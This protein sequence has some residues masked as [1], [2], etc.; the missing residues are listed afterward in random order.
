MK[1]I[2]AL[3]LMGAMVFSLTACGGQKENAQTQ[4]TETTS[5]LENQEQNE[6]PDSGDDIEG[7]VLE[8]AVTYAG[9]QVTDFQQIVDAFEQEY[10]CKV[11]IA[12]YGSDYE[13][14][15]KTRMAA[16]N[17][18]DVFMTHGW[19]IIR[20]KDYLMDLR[21]E[22]WV[23]DYDESALGVIQDKDGAIYVLMIAE[24]INGT[25]VNKQVCEAAGVDPYSIHTWDDFT[26]ACATIKA[27]GYTPISVI[28]NP[29]LLANMAGT[30]VSYE[31]GLAQDSEVML[32]GSWDWESYRTVLDVYEEW[33]DAGYFY[34]DAMTMND[35]DLVERYANNAGAFCL[36]N[37]PEIM[38]ACQ[39]LNP[40]SEFLF[41]PSFASKEGGKEFVGIGEGGAFGIW[42]DTQNEKAAKL[43]LEYMAR[44]EVAVK[45][46]ASTG[47]ISCLKSAMEIDDGDG[48]RWFEEMKEK[49]AQCD[50]LY[51]NL[52]D[53]Q[54][55]PS[56]MWPVF[57]NACSMLFDDHSESGKEEVLEYLKEN[58]Q[59][60]YE[61]AKNS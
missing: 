4:G 14:T 47:E 27:A 52:W 35:A 56:G 30:W 58:Y 19:S 46:N 28:P 61:A 48:L 49:C 45:M 50:I 25:A 21:D 38:I 37:G 15:L 13:S 33:I 5:D 22:P 51:E 42:K 31:G 7:S 23:A 32:D 39:S 60:L 34:E 36:G 54:Y 29:G 41:L 17:L 1:K 8:V 2:L 16:N 24:G 57:G 53:R 18:P 26:E 11:N 55:M 6:N 43:F 20:Y 59:D 12:E 3:L 44:P 40:E 9:V 10:G